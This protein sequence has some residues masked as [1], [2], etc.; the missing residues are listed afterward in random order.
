MRLAAR[1]PPDS[2]AAGAAHR[3][4]MAVAS[5]RLAGGRDQVSGA[6]AR[7]LW[8]TATGRYPPEELAWITRIEERRRRVGESSDALAPACPFWSVPRVWGRLLL[9]LVR[10]LEPRS[11]VELG[12]AF[13]VSASYQAA[14]LELAGSGRL[15]TLDREPELIPIAR[16]TLSALGLGERVELVVGPIG[17]TLPGVAQRAAPVDYAYID[18]EHT[19]QATVSNFETLLPHL[20]AGAVVVVDDVRVDEPMRRAWDRIRTNEAVALELDLRRFGVAVVGAPAS[21]AAE[22]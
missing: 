11:C 12:A 16:E 17:E 9:R 20:A 2:P 19:E 7:A 13:G 6:L 15:I 21:E 22:R 1:V 14:A 5:R 18:A 10:E 8:T 3:A 4:L